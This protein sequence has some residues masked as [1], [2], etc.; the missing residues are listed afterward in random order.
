[1]G[2]GRGGGAGLLLWA[3]GLGSAWAAG[4]DEAAQHRALGRQLFTQGAA[5]PCAVCHT[6]QDA[7]SQGAVGPVLDELKPDA[8]RVATALR[9]GVGAMPSYRGTL[10]EAQILALAAYVSKAAAGR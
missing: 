4:A 3:V 5:P 10:T 6:L 8:Q 7:G 1:M 2:G 9:N